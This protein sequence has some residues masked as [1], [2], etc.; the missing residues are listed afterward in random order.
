MTNWIDISQPL[1]ND[2]AFFPGDSPFRYSLSYT[3][4]ETGS[5]NIGEMQASLHN[6][7]HI[8]APFHYDSNGKTVD[9]LPL[10]LAIGKSIVLDVSDVEVV[11]DHVLAKHDIRG[12]T[13]VLLKTSLPNNP[14]V[15]P[16]TMPLLD[17]SV[18]AYL[19]EQGVQLLGVD[20][21]S[22]DAVDSKELATH[23]ALYQNNIYI[24]ENIML[25]HVET[26]LY[27]MI[28]LPLRII[29]ADASPV[30]VVIRPISDAEDL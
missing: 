25:D 6:G 21:P 14:K 11:T 22:V 8:D 24:L 26:G 19:G 27:E 7:T 16:K 28:A 17:P 3:K 30:R 4:E 20:L 15:F 12:I 10:D 2:L 5:V 23:H 9:T 13:R 18:A 29:G 1:T